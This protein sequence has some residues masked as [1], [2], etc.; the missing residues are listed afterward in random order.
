[1]HLQI[2][3]GDASFNVLFHS[4][5]NPMWIVEADTLKFMEVNEA[6]IKHYGYSRDEFLNSITLANIRP[7]YEQKDMLNL[8]KT[9]KHNQTVKTDLSH[10]KKDGSLIYVNITSFNVEFGGSLCRMVIINDV[11]ESKL[12]D[13]QLT[14]AVTKI[15][16]TLESITDGFITLDG[17]LRI[18]YWNK[19]AE[20]ILGISR[21][22]VLHKCLWE[23]YPN[24][25]RLEL[26]GQ[27]NNTLKR[28][29]T[30]KFEEYIA[31]LNKWVRFIVY[32]G[33]EG[34]TV[35]FRD[36]TLQKHGEKQIDL[37]NESL[38][39]IAYINSHIMRKPLANI[40][41]IINSLEY[42]NYD[43][44]SDQHIRMLKQSAIEL[45]NIIKDINSKV[46]RA[47]K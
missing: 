20:H 39:Q 3:E 7:V 37:K 32:P 17:E 44:H 27:L 21:D 46:E 28:K 42:T 10:I 29:E 12:K 43:E 16:D 24:Y 45:D 11:T 9:I 8:I 25:K 35:Y 30:V 15:R 41:G 34:L 4:N 14:E 22:T 19:E 6:A 13:I 18:T 47:N 38:D 1:M 33:V 2:S 5:P 40:L 31:A 26:F 36:I 23:V